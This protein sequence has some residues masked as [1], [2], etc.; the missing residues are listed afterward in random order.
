[1]TNFSN[2]RLITPPREEE[3]IYPFRRVWRSIIIENGT[4]IAIAMVLFGITFLGFSFPQPIFMPLNIALVLLPLALWIIFSYLPE[5]RVQQPRQ[6]LRLIIILS[7]LVANAIGYPIIRDI[8]QV[9]D[10]LALASARDR[11]I[12]YTV[13]VGILQEFLKYFIIRMMVWPHDLRNRYDSIAYGAAAAVGY[14]TVLNIQ[15]ILENPSSPE[16]VAIR[17][18][19]TV[20]MHLVG[21][22]IVAYGLSELWFSKA[23]LLLLPFTLILA[24]LI[25]G[26]SIPLRAGF[27]NAALGLTISATRPLFA[28]A[29]TLIVSV[30][31]MAA[32]YFL[33]NVAES[34]DEQIGPS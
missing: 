19:G 17:V 23:N 14:A 13:S 7:A 32:M 25:E 3:E 20:G 26:I 29:F 8:L 21:S 27:N 24:A 6:N 31:P 9:N 18:L 28:L 16:T 1:M 2:P 33:F 22:T 30:G 12:G 15:Y 4:L 34:R 5:L 11:I 10:W